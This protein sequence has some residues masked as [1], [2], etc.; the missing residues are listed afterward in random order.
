MQN[1][2][3]IVLQS[4]VQDIQD[5][6]SLIFWDIVYVYSSCLKMKTYISSSAC[7]TCVKEI[8]LP[9]PPYTVSLILIYLHCGSKKRANFGGL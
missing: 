6:A 8:K 4:T 3:V 1:F 9:L 7:T 5:Y 2:I